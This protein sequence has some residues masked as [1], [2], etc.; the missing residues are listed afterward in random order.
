MKQNFRFGESRLCSALCVLQTVLIS[1]TYAM[2]TNTDIKTFFPQINGN[3]S[4]V[5]WAHAVN[6]KEYLKKVLNNDKIMMI[7]ADIV[8]GKLSNQEDNIPIMAHPPNKTSDLSLQDFLDQISDFNEQAGIN[9]RQGKGVKLDFKETVAFTSSIEILK[10]LKKRHYPLWLNADILAGYFGTANKT[11]P[12]DAK[13]FLAYANNVEQVTLSLGWTTC[14]CVPDQTY[15]NIQI[16]EMIDTIHSNNVIN[17]ITFAVRACLIANTNRDKMKEL[18]D[19]TKNNN[20]SFTI[21]SHHQDEVNIDSLKKVIAQFGVESMFFDVPQE[22][23]EQLDL[24]T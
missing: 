1:V 11:E 23:R 19:S 12:V 21:W 16:Q 18:L 17:T 6:D 5:T 14:K 13:T 9:N 8:I 7:E 20:S 22:L 15:G 4:L 10:R 24:N 2:S 3:F